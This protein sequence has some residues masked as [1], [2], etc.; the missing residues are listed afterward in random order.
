MTA[1]NPAQACST[2]QG[3]FL[4]YFIQFQAMRELLTPLPVPTGL[5]TSSPRSL[6]AFRE[7]RW[8]CGCHRHTQHPADHVCLLLRK[9][10]QWL[11][12]GGT[13]EKESTLRKSVHRRL[14]MPVSRSFSDSPKAE[15][16]NPVSG[17]LQHSPFEVTSLWLGLCPSGSFHVGLGRAPPST[18]K[19]AFEP[20]WKCRSPGKPL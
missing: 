7:A 3:L 2:I 6:P 4:L 10:G 8:H 19:I 11:G 12:V 13:H 14:D 20:Q 1:G 17:H 18:S 9:R 16:S 5:T 15:Q